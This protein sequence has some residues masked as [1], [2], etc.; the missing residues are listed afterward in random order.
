M[1]KMNGKKAEGQNKTSRL[2]AILE[3]LTGQRAPIAW[4]TPQGLL[5]MFNRGAAGIG[6]SQMNELLLLLGYD[7]ISHAFFQY[8]VDGGTSYG[9]GAS[10]TSPEHLSEGVERFRK[11]ALLMFGNVKYAFKTLSQNDEA[12]E[13]YLELLEPIEESD[14]G[15]RHDPVLPIEEIAGE[16]TY[17]LGYL[18]QGEISDRLRIDPSDRWALGAEKKRKSVVEVGMRNHE[19]YLASDHL[20]VYVATSMRAK[21][22]YLMVNDLTRKIFRHESLA[23]LKLRWFD[24][25]Q[26]YCLDRIDKGLSEALMLKR[27]K[28]TVYFAQESDTLGKDSELASTLAQGKPVIAFV[29]SVGEREIEELLATLYSIYPDQSE[30]QILLDQLRVFEP[31]AA[32]KDG[33]VRSWLERVE[34]FD[35]DA[36]RI[37]LRDAIQRHY[38]QRAK[39]LRDTHPLGI[40]VNLG[41]GVANGVLVVRTIDHCAE[42]IRR[43][44]TKTLEFSLEEKVIDGHEY[45]LLKESI[46]GCIY[47]VMTGDAMLTNTFWN[48][49]LGFAD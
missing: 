47:R 26:A 6:Y 27:A 28:C 20:D 35:L 8:L 30:R 11:V 32:W 4:K 19:A 1:I 14:F 25:T 44:V 48:F 12:L 33:A 23:P 13:Y 46:S 38:D 16:D 31:N 36:G 37:R 41:T 39:T 2:S 10:I 18:I 24:P 49:Y 7:R 21:H 9:P 43:V 15:L 42:L 29:P 34:D 3:D 22:E 40:Q 17:Y 5:E 45:V